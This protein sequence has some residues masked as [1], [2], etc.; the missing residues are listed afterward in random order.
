MRRFL[1]AL[2]GAALAAAPVRAP[3][4]ERVSGP[5]SL[6]LSLEESVRL[7]V[8]RNPRLLADRGRVS[9]ASAKTGEARTAFFP[10][11][12][13]SAGYTRL[14]VAPYLP[15]SIFERI[16]GGSPLPGALPERI[17]IGRVDNYSASLRMEQPLYAGG[18][19]GNAHG[20]ARLAERAAESELE[21]S[22]RE[23]VFETK[24]AYLACVQ[25]EEMARLAAE[26]AGRFESQLA[27]VERM[28]E[29][30]LA[31]RNDV[32]KTKVYRA[33]AELALLR[34]RN[35]ARFAKDRLC[36][37]VD[38]PLGSGLV[39]STRA[40]SVS[41]S[42]V[43]L[44]AA[45]RAGLAG[46]AELRELSYRARMAE[47]EIAASRAG[48]LPDLSLFADLSW[49]NPDREY[50]PDFYSTWSIG[51]AARMNVFDWG[52]TLR[53]TEQARSRLR[54]LE[55][56]AR[57][58]ENAVALEVTRAHVSRDEA[59]RA[60]EVS[61]EA[62]ASAR[63]NHPVTGDRFREGLS[64]NTELLDAQVLLTQA[65]TALSGARIAYL[66]AEADLE[67]AMGGA[68]R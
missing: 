40:D 64:T 21:R 57:E 37:L 46:R 60:I 59:W 17:S 24:H 27:D 9:E 7:A 56:A 23:L 39:L 22:S 6:A 34:S 14:D 5:D 63:E 52:R 20:I 45:V 38:L 11:V 36:V 66:V 54:Q 32:L 35:A 16:S 25:A 3:A 13:A 42:A 41:R 55:A 67:R 29:T 62:L 8:E 51:V 15:T 1:C 53:R 4:R 68:P 48:Y 50:E 49:R 2:L 65:E 12:T 58:I 30:G 28:A 19:I 18:K 10:Q 43:D 44:E 33:E 26:T 31:A 61:R 47:R